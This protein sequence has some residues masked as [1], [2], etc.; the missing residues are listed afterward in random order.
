MWKLRSRLAT[1]GRCTH[2]FLIL[3]RLVCVAPAVRCAALQ[4][5]DSWAREVGFTSCSQVH[6]VGSTYAAIAIK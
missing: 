1:S 2:S 6:L 3:Q 5:F 4:E